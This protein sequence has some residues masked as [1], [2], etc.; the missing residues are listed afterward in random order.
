MCDQCRK[1]LKRIHV[2]SSLLYMFRQWFADR[3][4]QFRPQ[5][6]MTPNHADHDECLVSCR[7]GELIARMDE[8]AE[9]PD[10][11]GQDSV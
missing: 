8:F 3:A 4:C 10:M 1:Y 2:L 7:V 6:V 11:K 9:N 5:G